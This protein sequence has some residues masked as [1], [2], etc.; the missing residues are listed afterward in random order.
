MK[1]YLQWQSGNSKIVKYKNSKSKIRTEYRALSTLAVL[2][3]RG[4]NTVRYRT[5][6][7]EKHWSAEQRRLVVSSIWPNGNLCYLLAR[8]R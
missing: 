1:R 8:L 2:Y 7:K 3:T 5:R 6:K 4:I